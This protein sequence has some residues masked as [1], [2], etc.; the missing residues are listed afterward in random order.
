MIAAR[1]GQED[2][3]SLLLSRGADP[4]ESSVSIIVDCIY[5]YLYHIL[6]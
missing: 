5:P 1:E 3:V 4:S 2:I 6:Y